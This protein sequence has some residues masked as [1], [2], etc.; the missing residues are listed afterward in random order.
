MH[1]RIQQSWSQQILDRLELA[2]D[3][4]NPRPSS[5]FRRS[6]QIQKHV[7]LSTDPDNYIIVP[8][9]HFSPAIIIKKKPIISYL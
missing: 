2:T 6:Q 7:E 3:H 4:N 8:V 1:E 9:R 5:T